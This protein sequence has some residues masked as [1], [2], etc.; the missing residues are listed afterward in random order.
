MTQPP[1]PQHHTLGLAGR[2]AETFVASKLTLLFVL[3]SLL[4]G[5][6]ATV[7]LPREEEPQINV[8]M[9]DVFVGYPG[10]SSREVEDRLTR[11]GERKFWEIPDVEYVYSTSE[12]GLA[13]FIL[14][15]K[16]G[17]NPEEAM[18]RVYTK[19]FANMDFLP[20]GA[21]QPLVKPR[22]ID[23]VP[24]LA[25][26]LTGE[27]Q[28]AYSLRTQAA[29]LREEISAVPGVSAT[30]IIGGRR[31]QFL[32]HFDPAAL[33]RHRLTPLELAGT[34][35]AANTR[36]PAGTTHQ[37][38]R[39]VAVET[40]ALIRSVEDLKR[41]VVGVSS[42]RAVTLADV[43][44]I[45]DGP[46]EE[47]RSVSE[48]TREGKPREAVTLA[49]SKRRGQNATEVAQEV[50]R[51][52]DAVRP[53]LLKK[54]TKVS[55]TRNYGETAKEKSDE[56]LY[57]MALATLSVTLLIALFLGVRE[58]L[59]VLVA[60]PVTLALTLLVYSLLGYTLNR[61]TLFALIF[62]IGILV[63][64]AIVV[65]EN[66]HRHFAMRDGRS[67]RQLAVDAVAE[68]GNPTILATWAVIAAI[69]PMAFVSGLMGPYM[70]PI[71]VGAS[72]AMIFSL[73][74]AFVI[75]PWAFTHVLTIWKPKEVSGH[76]EES[77]LDRLYRKFM[78][79]LL[80][81]TLS[82][83]LYLG[84][85]VILLL[86]AMSLVYFKKVTLK[87][88]PFDNKNEFEVVLTLPEGT[89]LEHTQKAADEISRA[90]L[91]E[92]TEVERVTSY[93]GTAAPYNFNGLVRHYFLRQ[94]PHQADLAVNLSDKKNRKRQSHAVAA[95]LRPVVQVIADRYDA[96][97]QVAEIPPGP[98]VLST[99]V[100]EVYGPDNGARDAFAKKLQTFLRTADDIVDVDTY[101]PTVEPLDLVRVDRE[102][103][104]LNGLSAAHIAQTTSLALGGQT[105]GLASTGVDKDDVEIRLRLSPKDR[106]G[107]DALG[108]INLLSRNGTLIP[109]AKL[110][111]QER[112]ERD[113]PIYHKNLQR[114][115]YV[116]AD[117][118]GQQE[119][120]VYAIL[121]LRKKI[122]DLAAESGYDVKEYFA[123][124]PQ[125]SL[126]RALKWD[127]EWQITYEVFRDLGLAFAFALVLIYVLVVGWFK[128]FT[129]PL[130]VMV[131]IPLTL[132]GILPAHWGLG[133]FFTAT[134]M[135][136]FIA[137]AGIVV[138]NSII[139][140]DFIHLRLAEGMP[141]KEAV[142]DAGAVRFRPMLLTAAAVVAGA[143]VI[144]FDPIFQGLAVALMAGEIA[145]TVLSRM[146]V[147]VLYYMVA[148]REK[149]G[150]P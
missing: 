112:V 123:S 139:L 87:M 120:P 82:R 42:G 121:A 92:A 96:R 142:I 90:L 47:D 138:R 94:R 98:P 148:R 26:N 41:I 9:F 100:F 97:V 79:R 25:L 39:V 145:S 17:T 72:V 130:V 147:P 118:A 53:S 81:H 114:V 83:W 93:V 107:L 11:V 128:S 143:G 110:T 91:A 85:T 111:N 99:L 14:R 129:I 149:K 113:P 3:A 136:G 104:T 137:G 23:D 22:S 65:V 32:I 69:L 119:S 7:S 2:L 73:G 84:A 122:T 30:E 75:S 44:Q 115:S 67:L 43:A 55:V 64:D 88:L 89:A 48:W 27:G 24:I 140:V 150:H 20:P 8:P 66:I 21:T 16:V 19:T 109:L 68:V 77:R 58:A 86:G 70:R 33:A 40:D 37:G 62:S 133:A 80:T 102:K 28:D 131:P 5:L 116:I 29:A 127:G 10:A 31:R 134:S 12:P 56:L 6:F 15:F 103:V 57:H 95:S 125:N 61:I 34:V 144:L 60:I 35:Q 18:T 36:L 108:K 106:G 135:I 146:A 49:V 117:V 54:E 38:N 59:V 124:S 45:T 71:P 13:M 1:P 52:I 78:G 101:V 50:M 46:D 74:I 126:E 141:L 76:G 132:V 63:D 4:L 105:L 51:R